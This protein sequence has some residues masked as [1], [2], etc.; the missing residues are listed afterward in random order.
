MHRHADRFAEPVR[1]LGIVQWI[2]GFAA[3]ATLPV[4]LHSFGWTAWLIGAVDENAGGYAIFNVVRYAF[5]L[6]VMLPSTFCAGITL[7]LITRTLV[8]NGAGERAIGFVYGVNTLGSIAGVVLAGLVLLPLLGLKLLLVQGAVLDMAL[9]VILLR[10]ATRE[11]AGGRRLTLAA[12][13]GVVVLV[14]VAIWGNDFDRVTLSSGV[15]RYG[16]VA[17]AESKDV[18]FYEDGRTAS[19]SVSRMRRGTLVIATNGKPDAS[20]DSAWQ[21]PTPEALP[22]SL[23]GDLPTQVL[24][25]LMTLAHAPHARSAAVIGQGSGMSSHF[26][27]GSPT[28]EQLVTIEIEPEMIA[29]SRQFYPANKR[30]FDDPRA[31]FAIEDA[32]SYFAAERRTYDLILSEPSNP[33]VSGV[34]GLFTAEFYQRVRRYLAPNG[35]FGQWLHL[36]EIDDQLVL[37][38]LAALHQS[39][40]SYQIFLTSSGDVL[41]VASLQPTLPAPDW[42]VFQY[43]AV[44]KDLAPVIPFTPRMLEATRILSREVLAPL[45]DRWP[46]PNS[47]FYPVLDLG[48]ERTRF[49]R[50]SA[51]GFQSIADDRFDIVAPFMGQRSEFVDDARVPVPQIPRMHNLALSALVRSPFRFVMAESADSTAAA[52]VQRRWLFEEGMKSGRTP[53]DWRAWTSQLL[54]VDADIH[55][56]TAGVADEIFYYDVRQYAERLDAPLEV[57]AVIAFLRS[58]S[59]WDWNGASAAADRLL[60]SAQRGRSWI[61]PDLLRDGAV[62]AKLQLGDAEGARRVFS[63]L[64]DASARPVDDFR[65]Q[66]LWSYIVRA[67]R[68][69]PLPHPDTDVLANRPM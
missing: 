17:S 15:F 32:K 46:R 51:L 62:V 67:Q 18:I 57:R 43:P 26:L 41:I 21:H 60:P 52:A 3:L 42:S 54:A 35:V 38:V 40:P 48:G 16:R 31:R 6:A 7:P 39:F 53:P 11:S 1:A 25:P 27:L 61:S 45:L 47:D 24:L 30:V 22:R 19:V 2:M 55:G 14:E 50:L 44:A 68:G 65:V 28:L 66:L 69:Q 34:S 10:V 64:V 56:G 59:V 29:G 58:I 12:A 5:C 20:L 13:V 36:Y 33:W 8:A 4:Y 23:G 49:M 63:S 9:G 37:G